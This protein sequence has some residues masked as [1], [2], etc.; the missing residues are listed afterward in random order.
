MSV[1]NPFTEEEKEPNSQWY[2]NAAIKA[3]I[4][5]GAGVGGFLLMKGPHGRLVKKYLEGN[6]FRYL[7]KDTEKAVHGRAFDADKPVASYAL[8]PNAKIPA[9]NSSFNEDLVAPA[10]KGNILVKAQNIKTGEAHSYLIHH[11]LIKTIKSTENSI[12]REGEYFMGEKFKTPTGELITKF[13]LRDD[14]IFYKLRMETLLD[15][16]SKSSPEDIDHLKAIMSDNPSPEKVKRVFTYYMENDPY[17]ASMYK[18]RLTRLS[19]NYN[20]ARAAFQANDPSVRSPKLVKQFIYG[21]EF[22]DSVT[23]IADNYAF[24]GKMRHGFQFESSENFSST[25]DL[26]RDLDKGLKVTS[27]SLSGRKSFGHQL[28]N[29][30]GTFD[31]TSRLKNIKTKLISL[32]D[33]T[34]VTGV[35]EIGLKIIQGGNRGK[36]QWHVRVSLLHDTIKGPGPGGAFIV[37]IP[38]NQWGFIPGS[39]PS[40]SERLDGLLIEKTNFGQRSITD[41]EIINTSQLMF[42]DVGAKLDG[43][44]FQSNFKKDPMGSMN[45]LN[46]MITSKTSLMPIAKGEVRDLFQLLR[47][48]NPTLSDLKANRTISQGNMRDNIE[49]AVRSMEHMTEIR[50][51]R[52]AFSPGT[53]SNKMTTRPGVVSIAIDFETISIKSAGTKVGPLFM[54]N[55]SYTQ[56]TKGGITVSEMDKNGIRTLGM[57]E[58]VSDHGFKFFKKGEESGGKGY[59]DVDTDWLKQTLP[60]GVLQ[61]G[62]TDKEIV[63]QWGKQ[64]SRESKNAAVNGN[65]GGQSKSGSFSNN[66]EMMHEYAKRVLDIVK[67]HADQGKDVYLTTKHGTGFDIPL[68]KNWAPNEWAALP[69]HIKGMI[70][71][72]SVAYYY[73]KGFGGYESLKLNKVLYNMMD[74]AGIPAIDIEG[75]RVYRSKSNIEVA[76]RRI[77]AKGGWIA[78]DSD[79][80]SMARKY[81][82]LAAHESPSADALLA[83]V[84]LQ[85]DLFKAE[86]GDEFFGG[87]G[88]LKE[89]LSSGKPTMEDGYVA[90]MLAEGTHIGRFGTLSYGGPSAGMLGKGIGSCMHLDM[91]IPMTDIKWS[92][93]YD[94]LHRGASFGP[95]STFMQKIAESYGTTVNNLNDQMIRDSKLYKKRFSN[96]LTTKT[97][98]AAD[99]FI[100]YN[101]ASSR[102][103][104][105]Q[106]HVMAKH[107]YVWNAYMGKGGMSKVSNGLLNDVR[108]HQEKMFPLD[109]ITFRNAPELLNRWQ[110][111]ETDIYLTAK[112]MGE[113]KG[114]GASREIYLAA[115]REVSDR[116]NIIIPANTEMQVAK[117]NMGVE[118][119]RSEMAGKV[120]DIVLAKD[121]RGTIRVHASLLFAAEGEKLREVGM[122]MRSMGGKSQV[123]TNNIFAD[124]NAYGGRFI[125]SNADFLDKGY[126]SAHKELLLRNL[127]DKI[128]SYAE[129]GE[130][131]KVQQAKNIR[132]LMLEKGKLN[133]TWADGGFTIDD[134]A[135]GPE[136][137]FQGKKLTGHEKTI[138][139][140]REVSWDELGGWMKNMGE[141]YDATMLKRY[142]GLLTDPTDDWKEMRNK[143]RNQYEKKINNLKTKA[144]N[145]ESLKIIHGEQHAK[146]IEETA[147]I[148]NSMFLPEVGT[149]IFWGPVENPE[150]GRDSLG[151]VVNDRTVFYNINAGEEVKSTVVKFRQEY[152]DN[153][154]VEGNHVSP[155]VISQISNNLAAYKTPALYA[156]KKTIDNFNETLLAKAMMVKHLDVSEIRQLIRPK[157]KFALLKESRRVLQQGD[158]EKIVDRL[159][160]LMDFNSYADKNGLQE[161]IN[162]IVTFLQSSGDELKE[163]NLDRFMTL[164]ETADW[165]NIARKKKVFAISAEKEAGKEFVF[166]NV[167]EMLRQLYNPS[168]AKKYEVHS[169]NLIELMTSIMEKNGKEGI[170]SGLTVERRV[171]KIGENDEVFTRVI[172]DKFRRDMLKDGEEIIGFRLNTFMMAADQSPELLAN[173]LGSGVGYKTK[174]TILKHEVLHSAENYM[175]A[176]KN[177]NQI[178]EARKEFIHDAFKQM[179]RGMSYDTKSKYWQALNVYEL[180]GLRA[181]IQGAEPILSKALTIYEAGGFGKKGYKGVEGY[182][183]NAD[184]ANAL[185]ARLLKQDANTV[186]ITEQ[187]FN[188]MNVDVEQYGMRT[189]TSFKKHVKSEFKKWG[190]SSEEQM[191]TFLNDIKTGR[192]RATGY[193]TRF[194]AQQSAKDGVVDVFY[195]V[196]PNDIAP[197]LGVNNEAM[198]IHSLIG[199]RIGAD[200]DG[201][202]GYMMLNNLGIVKNEFDYHNETAKAFANLMQRPDMAA[203]VIKSDMLMDVDTDTGDAIMS[204]YNKGGIFG[205]QRVKRGSVDRS[206]M[207]TQMFNNIQEGMMASSTYMTPEYAASRVAHAPYVALS[208]QNVGMVTNLVRKRTTQVMMA[209][210]VTDPLEKQFL[211]GNL[212]HGLAGFGQEIIDLAKHGTEIAKFSKIMDYFSYMNPKRN[213][214][215]RDLAKTLWIDKYKSDFGVEEGGIEPM[216]GKKRLSVFA[217]DLFEKMEESVLNIQN[218]QKYDS[219]TKV[220]MRAREDAMMGR[221]SA[222]MVSQLIG[223]QDHD[224]TNITQRMIDASEGISRQMFAPQDNAW[225]SFAKSFKNKFQ[226]D[227]PTISTFKKGGKYAGIAA[228]IFMALNFFRPNQ[229]SNSSN[230]LDMFVDLGHDT[231]GERVLFD[232]VMELDRRN[233]LDMVDASFSR[234]AYLKMNGGK[235]DQSRD[236]SNV[237]S[238]LLNS[239]LGLDPIHKEFKSTNSYSSKNY[240][241]NVGFFGNS[242]IDRR[243]NGRY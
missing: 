136:Y 178:E 230:P 56:V 190:S 158:P 73:Q 209:D 187:T 176:V 226:L 177:G 183:G 115:A 19:R 121:A 55:N 101:T 122:T 82:Y 224:F 213:L 191:G 30:L 97:L 14:D 159:K 54:A 67:F 146:I 163:A 32:Q 3:S 90:M 22:D 166:D 118:T 65:W 1:Y 120:Q 10:I 70:D 205:V 219:R 195:Q 237:V 119:I 59:N 114:T 50:K 164:S 28:L 220:Q 143:V 106:Q 200:D 196:I 111:M 8:G 92:K 125:L 241:T 35:R 39:N 170:V 6:V 169:D 203:K 49:E 105:F 149:P 48:I 181:P 15:H 151:L 162:E 232:N 154:R 198:H 204:H 60:K 25:L 193:M 20:S 69:R 155:G 243:F 124:A 58:L 16:F 147:R 26:L 192:T 46:R 38:V 12:L 108:V 184:E 218:R 68:L 206:E 188:K 4:M 85:G 215:G 27:S 153:I 96:P 233:P 63:E 7:K 24:S 18:K 222:S 91:I 37:D 86:A 31:Y 21:G 52:R 83:T 239:S 99:E 182:K 223:A 44:L 17:Y 217:G 160:E 104:Y 40:S 236:R 34:E 210:L 185:L 72:H 13:D 141:T 134:M 81:N 234:Q 64:I 135:P 231:N 150:T 173:M 109:S 175:D 87:I 132:K 133:G 131:N 47:V 221:E 113:Q 51:A 78:K 227:T 157:N 199:D 74:R 75:P 214:D 88:K 36:K 110:N 197:Y 94:Q 41:N 201:D 168:Q 126:A 93:Q 71:V 186:M 165:V 145:D 172:R 112:R 202:K 57:E 167:K 123:S 242:N 211:V 235:G 79:V 128:R 207:F 130:P 240:T 66:G 80:L 45:S 9:L 156:A 33:N 98:L 117:G 42:D 11:R 189:S 62:E 77:K 116:Y 179:V 212:R 127:M 129:S 2:K 43:V 148:Q 84:L 140:N 89:V 139:G 152:L 76:L 161:E 61:G 107:I 103:N 100:K 29:E 142:Y 23:R 180:T 174:G 138:L 53:V 208:K 102:A 171:K 229:L 228:G 95:S 194:P 5:G 137:N 144:M 216:I 225:G 238:A